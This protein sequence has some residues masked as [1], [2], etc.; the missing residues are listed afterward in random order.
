MTLPSSS[1]QPCRCHL[2]LPSD[3]RQLYRTWF[4]WLSL[5]V[6]GS[7][8]GLISSWPLTLESYIALVFFCLSLQVQGLL[9][10]ELY[11]FCMLRQNNLNIAVFPML[12]FWSEIPCFTKLDTL[13]STTAFKTALKNERKKERKKG[14]KC[15][16]KKSWW[17]NT[18]S[19]GSKEKSKQVKMDRIQMPAA[20]RNLG[21]G[22][23]HQKEKTGYK[24]MPA[25]ERTL[26]LGKQT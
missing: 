19:P 6:Q 16:Q 25:E 11:I 5:Q 12:L 13:Q 14:T 15:K 21:S 23:R 1:R 20:E 7:H 9:T 17:K 10:L 18:F 24:E 22:S 4:L 2:L 8:V 26:W 3:P